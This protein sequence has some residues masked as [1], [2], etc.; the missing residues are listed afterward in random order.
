M[1]RR[2]RVSRFSTTGRV[3]KEDKRALP[4]SEVFLGPLNCHVHAVQGYRSNMEDR[5]A[6]VNP[7]MSDVPMSRVCI[8]GVFDGH[9]GP[10]CAEALSRFLPESLG[11]AL[12]NAK[13][14]FDQGTL[15]KDT[16]K[17]FDA[18]FC[19]FAHDQQLDD[20][21]TACVAIVQR[22]KDTGI[23]DHIMIANTGD[24]RAVVVRK[25]GTV[26]QL[27]R[28]HSASVEDEQAR[29]V[30]EG[31][32]I[33]Y[34]TS[35]WGDLEDGGIH[36]VNGI[37]AMTRAFGNR[38]LK[39]FVTAEPEISVRKIRKDDMY[40]C[41]ASDGLWDALS[42]EQ[43]GEVLLRKGPKVGVEELCKIALEKGSLDNV[44]VLAVNINPLA[45]C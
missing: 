17:S 2:V 15:V 36:R 35:P 11:Y 24:S 34:V 32:Y 22:D 40:L 21:S 42:N 41:I 39:P 14:D 9:A 25:S 12:S 18:D 30:D 28:D 3:S 29:V 6:L 44:T 23:P 27:S 31:G 19:N 7:P 37:L 8:A 33:Q 4:P 13:E 26:K 20:G 38:T 43:V 16:F 10:M 45:I 1:W 5:Y